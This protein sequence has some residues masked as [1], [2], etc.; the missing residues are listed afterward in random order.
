M[1][2]SVEAEDSIRK[3][4]Y[5]F[6][7][8]WNHHDAHAFAS[9]FAEESFFSNVVGMTAKG[10]Q[11]IE[12]FHAPSFETVFKNSHQTIEDINIR[13]VNPTIASVDLLWSM[14]GV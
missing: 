6:V 9:V 14:T 1:I 5:R 3:V 2:N 8:A 12:S 11:G 10:R 4:I 13:L 7:D